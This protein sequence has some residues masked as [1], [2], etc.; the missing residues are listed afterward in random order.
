MNQRIHHIFNTKLL[1]QTTSGII[2][3]II[4]MTYLE[5]DLEMK[6]TTT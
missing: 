5:Y 6:V 1:K 2:A 4:T 3:I